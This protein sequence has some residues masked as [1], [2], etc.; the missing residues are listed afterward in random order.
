MINWI[1]RT[2]NRA[3]ITAYLGPRIRVRERVGLVID[4]VSQLGLMTTVRSGL[5]RGGRLHF[6]RLLLQITDIIDICCYHKT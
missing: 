4:Q 3:I 2:S 6:V 5:V 1:P